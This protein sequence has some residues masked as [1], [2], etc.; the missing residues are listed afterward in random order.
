MNEQERAPAYE[1][2]DRGYRNQWELMEDEMSVLD[3]RLYLFYQ[4]HQWV[5]PK[6]DMKNMLGFVVTREEFEHN[7]LKAAQTGLEEKLQ[8]EEA[9]QLALNLQTIDLRLRKTKREDFPLLLLF[10]RFGLG[11]FEQECVLLA[12]ASVLDEK[13]EKLFAY[14]QDD[15]T[16]K[17]P[18]VSLAISLLMEKG[19]HAEQYRSMLA[20]APSFSLLFEPELW[21]DGALALNQEV[22]AFLNGETRLPQGY[23]LWSAGTA[24]PDE[25]LPVLAELGRQLDALFTVPSCAGVLSGAPGSGRHYQ[26][27]QLCRRYGESCLFADL[28]VCGREPE[29]VRRGAM[30]ARMTDSMLCIVEPGSFSQEGEWQAPS[31]ELADAIAHADLARGRLFVLSQKPLHLHLNIPMLE[32]EVPELD[33]GER[34]ILFRKCFERLPLSE[35]VSMQELASKF[36]F[37]PRQ[38]TLAAQQAEGIARIAEKPLDAAQL[39]QCCYGQVVHKLDTLAGRI[40]PGCRWEDLVL[41]EAQKRLIQQAC[42]H[43]RWQHRVFGEWGF[44]RKIRYGTGLSILFDGVPGTGKTMCAQIMAREL[45]MEMYKINI[46]QIVS[47]Y[48][49]ET[50]KNLQ[51]VF[52]EAKN[53][54]CILFFDECDAIF[55]KRS[56]VKDSHDRNANVETAYL[57]QQIEEFDGV[58]ILATNLLQNIDEAFLRR[59]TFVIHF[60]F[61]DAEMREKIYRTTL[62]PEAP[63]D[64]DVDWKFLAEKF[65]LSGGYIKNIVLAASF[66]A[67]QEG[68]KIGMKHFL[69]AA[70]NELKKNEIVVVRESLQEYADLLMD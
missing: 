59:I 53:S 69:N 26:V 60:P 12:Y 25:G 30:L 22:L 21:K 45:N 17:K 64:D 14:L 61:P 58:C 20:A 43:V 46:S 39:H 52:R 34:L 31:P 37:T 9:R 68:T 3:Y 57:L 41:P 36:H 35:N 38:I 13:Y 16:K 7:L 48:I 29:A 1:E 10:D 63:V 54:N 55:G 67:A 2:V 23:T 65:E 66:M 19:K 51:A 32:F 11:S 40:R 28:A 27:E 33:A 47:K 18:T 62:P 8:P 4:Y 24:G 15:I 70:V 49:G 44:G 5:G 50:E 42:A 56:E 6:N